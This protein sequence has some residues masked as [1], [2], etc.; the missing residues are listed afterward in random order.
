MESGKFEKDMSPSD[1]VIDDILGV[2]TNAKD[3][4]DLRNIPSS[5]TIIVLSS[6]NSDFFS[7]QKKLHLYG[8]H[9]LLALG[10]LLYFSS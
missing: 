1:N 3:D 6:L 8:S 7:L 10:R 2:D 9:C 4:W 5:G